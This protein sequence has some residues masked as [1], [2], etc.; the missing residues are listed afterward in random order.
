MDKKIPLSWGITVQSLI[1]VSQK[2]ES[3]T[4][5][6]R[7][8]RAQVTRIFNQVQQVHDSMTPS[9]IASHTEKLESLKIELND[10]NKA[11]HSLLSDDVD[12]DAVL[13]EEERYHDHIID[14]LPIL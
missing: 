13:E 10:V 12:L 7:Y 6:R 11:I 8:L 14:T 5:S 3:L 1:S 9:K 4:K 2:L